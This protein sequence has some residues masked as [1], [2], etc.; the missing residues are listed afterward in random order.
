[1]R[2]DVRTDI[3]GAIRKLQ[4][5]ARDH[6]PFAVARALTDCALAVQDGTGEILRRSLES[7]TPFT[8]DRR[9]MFVQ[10]ADK[11]RLVAT[12][13]FKPR[14]SAYLKYQIDGGTRQP[15]RKALRLPSE[16]PLNEFGNLPSRT[17]QTLIARARQGKG[18]TKAQ[19]RRLRLSSKTSIFYGDP[20]DGRPPGIYQR[21]PL[22]GNDANRLIP[23]IVFPQQ[24]A[25]YKAIVP[26]RAEAERI[27]RRSIGPAFERR[28][29]EALAPR[30]RRSG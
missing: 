1:M 6:V 11:R 30:N 20:G 15:T 3:E 25:R 16:Q 2:L 22:P 28:L 7:P 27:V 17:I 8:T 26:W 18:V 23:L 4:A 24:V 14:Q 9:G 10:R 12:V 29:R 21:V 19:G 5:A 13:G